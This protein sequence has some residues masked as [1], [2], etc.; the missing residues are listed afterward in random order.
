[1]VSRSRI[2]AAGIR[3]SL[4]LL[5]CGLFIGAGNASG[6]ELTASWVDNSGGVATTRIERRLS[7]D[8]GFVPLADVPP[9]LTAYT[10]ASVSAGQT[11]CY[12]ALAYDANGVSPYSDE[13]CATSASSPTT[14]TL[15]VTVSTAGT[16]TGLVTSTPPGI[17][18]DPICAVT[19][20]TTSP[21]ITLAATPAAGSTFAG[22][23]GDCIGTST[24]MLTGEAAVTAT[25]TATI[26]ATPPSA[27]STPPV[28]TLEVPST[29]ARKS[30][31]TLGAA[32]SDDVGVVKVDFY[33]N[34]SK[35]LCSDSTA[36]YTCSWQIPNAPNKTWTLQ[37]T[38][39]D[40]VGNV[41]VSSRITVVPQ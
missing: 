31:I 37:A 24:C 10:D 7:V 16:G 18:C 5:A 32:A 2:P 27:D 12:R 15:D 26:T 25:F 13:V 9:G 40:A 3:L 11:Y 22:W 6:A 23:S 39:T 41:G 14:T 33:V 38:A 19:F 20:T 30:K 21:S 34:E 8:T 29:F 4:T 36:P 35:L 1:M 28:V 17:S